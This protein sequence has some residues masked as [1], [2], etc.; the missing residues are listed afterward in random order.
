MTLHMSVCLSVRLSLSV[1]LCLC[2]CLCKLE[3]IEMKVAIFGI[4]DR[5]EAVSV[6]INLERKGLK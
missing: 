1:S 6:D 4:D 5:L 3:M 2:D